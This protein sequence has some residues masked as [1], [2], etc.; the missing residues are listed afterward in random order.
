MKDLSDKS[1]GL[2]LMDGVGAAVFG[3]RLDAGRRC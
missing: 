2:G 1:K 3:D